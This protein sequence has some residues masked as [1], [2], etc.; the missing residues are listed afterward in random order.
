MGAWQTLRNTPFFVPADQPIELYFFQRV[1]CRLC[2]RKGRHTEDGR[3]NSYAQ[4]LDARAR[5]EKADLYNMNM[6]EQILYDED[7]EEKEVLL[8]EFERAMKRLFQVIKDDRIFNPHEYDANANGKVGWLEFCSLWKEKPIAIR[9][10]MPERIFL[11]FEDAE[12]SILGRIM[13]VLVFVTIL[14]STGSFIISTL[15]EMQD[16]CPLRGE[17]SF[18][19]DCR[20]TMKKYFNTIDLVCIMFFTFEYGIRLL[21]SACMR[22]EL[23]DRDMLLH[24]MVTDEVIKPPRFYRR[25]WGF[26]KNW[27]NL[28][29]MAAILPWYFSQMITDSRGVGGTFLSIIRLMRVVRAIRLARRFEAVIIIMRS[30]RKSLRALNVL[31]LNLCL[32]MLI[33][34]ALMYFAEQGTWNPETLAWE[35]QGA[36]GYPEK[37]PFES[38]PACFW[39]A[40][41]TATTV[42]YGD[43]HTPTTAYGK[44]IAGFSMVWSVCVLALPIG[45]IGGN[46][47]QVWKEYDLEKHK[48]LQNKQREDMML[49]KSGC[50]GDPL[51]YS[52]SLLIE[53]WHDSGIMSKE[54]VQ[55]EF[56]GE[57]DCMLTLPPKARFSEQRTLKVTPNFDKA[58]RQVRGQLT[59]EYSWEPTLL[60]DSDDEALMSGTL[61]VRIIKGVGLQSIGWKGKGKN[62]IASS[63]PFCII[64]AHPHSPKEDGTL[65]EAIQRT[66]MLEN[67]TNPFWDETVN[68]DFLW[69]GQVDTLQVRPAPSLQPSAAAGG[70][71]ANRRPE[72]ER[73]SLLSP[74][75]P[76]VADGE[77][78][79]VSLRKANSVSSTVAMINPIEISP[80]KRSMT[81]L[82]SPRISTTAPRS[83]RKGTN[84]SPRACEINQNIGAA[85]GLNKVAAKP[86]LQASPRQPQTQENLI[87]KTVPKLEADVAQLKAA[88]PQLQNEVAGVRADLQKI[89][90]VLLEKNAQES[91]LQQRPSSVT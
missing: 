17:E 68:F 3:N 51:H 86:L 60:K 9:L 61:Q 88:V 41:V 38:I 89:L 53:I 79:R 36:D 70:S 72:I 34:G 21:L 25:A 91:S 73:K 71:W 55:A 20:P 1:F 45:V 22:T 47:I 84:I 58:R 30:Q 16:T 82:R 66:R 27:C 6:G 39:W 31:V 2:Q 10:S 67:T 57:V 18:D 77:P 43:M 62:A 33:F 8:V 76:S 12:R 50:W 32:G 40:I 87:N 81:S 63:D 90:R 69:S 24:R 28:I 65:E 56:L 7:I 14:I 46:F 42:G 44:I 74:D 37:N 13:S 49:K 80:P 78:S 19:E 64:V 4:T 59:F 29:D 26:V 85:K 5:R 11:V 23:V 83:P 75:S 35:R 15:P 48:N 54:A 52:K